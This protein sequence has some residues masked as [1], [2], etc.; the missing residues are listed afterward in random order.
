MA[1]AEM[2]VNCALYKQGKKIREISLDSIS[3]EL[4]NDKEVFLWL[5]LREPDV[6]IMRKIQSELHLHELA[7]EDAYAAHQRPKL[8]EYGD[9]LFVALRTAEIE[10][11]DVLFGET[12]IFVSRRFIVTVRHGAS[13]SY[14]KVRV[15]CESLPDRML[16]GGSFILYAIMDFVVDNYAP[17][18]DNLEH[19]FEKFE[20]Q[21]F[22]YDTSG[23]AYLKELYQL[24]QQLIQLRTAALPLLDICNQ[25]MRFHENLIA[26]DGRVYYRDIHDHVARLIETSDRIREMVAVA[27]QVGLAQITIHQN[28]IVKKLAGW[29]AILAIP[30]MVFSLYGMNFKY[31]PELVWRWSYPA[32]LGGIVIACTWMYSRLKRVEWL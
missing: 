24:K 25:L 4:E 7:V 6:A 19:R 23:K 1:N 28:E 10:G 13:R 12:H 20:E 15:H 16:H 5:G 3:E 29:G 32:V 2:V 18:M 26:K 31:M 17:I 11:Q 22:D 9:T 8:E 21:L 30:T 14:G 27:M